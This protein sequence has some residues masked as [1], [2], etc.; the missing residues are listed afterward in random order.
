MDS[1]TKEYAA[2][3]AEKTIALLGKDILENGDMH[4]HYDPETGRGIRNKGFQSWNLLALELIW[5]EEGAEPD[6]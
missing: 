1:K 6:F 4:E 5:E 3:I 2:A